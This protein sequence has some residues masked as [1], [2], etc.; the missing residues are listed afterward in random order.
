MRR[1]PPIEAEDEF[2]EVDLEMGAAEAMVGAG[3]PCLEVRDHAVHP[4]QDDVSR[5]GADDVGLVLEL[6]Q[7]GVCAPAV[8]LEEPA[9]TLALMNG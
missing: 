6:R 1:A 4:R 2:V 5:H 7:A 8:G 3:R 9:A